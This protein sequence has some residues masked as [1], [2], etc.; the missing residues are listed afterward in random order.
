[1]QLDLAPCIEMI[2]PQVAYLPARG[3]PLQYVDTRGCAAAFVDALQMACPQ[4]DVII[5]HAEAVDLARVL[6][7][8]I[9]RPLLLAGDDPES[10]KHAYASCKVLVQRCELMTY[11]LL[12]AASSRSPRLTAIARSLS[13]CAEQFLGALLRNCALADPQDAATAPAE[14]GLLHLLRAQLN[15]DTLLDSGRRSGGRAASHAFETTGAG[16]A[17]P[18]PRQHARAAQARLTP[19]AEPFQNHTAY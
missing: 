6:K 7:N 3:L 11:D 13:G 19:G 16:T 8:R 14:A 1:V 12:L 17:S 2:S 4:A 18:R 5:L 10:L 15:L 9:A